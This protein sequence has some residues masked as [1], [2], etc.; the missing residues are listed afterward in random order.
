MKYM[1]LDLYA[2]LL[3]AGGLEFLAVARTWLPGSAA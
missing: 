3:S 1:D 2:S